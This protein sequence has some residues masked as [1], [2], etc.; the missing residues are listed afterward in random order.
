ME[1]VVVV[2]GVVTAAVVVT[3]VTSGVTGIVQVDALQIM[4]AGQALPHVL[5]EFADEFAEEFEEMEGNGK[6]APKKGCVF[7]RRNPEGPGFFCSI[8]CPPHHLQGISLLPDADQPPPHRV[9]SG[10]THWDQRAQDP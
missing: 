7:T 10:K 2:T 9:A 5:P 4:P 6:D 1:E 3:V 8:Y